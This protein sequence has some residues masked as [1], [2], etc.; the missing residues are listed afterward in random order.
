LAENSLAVGFLSDTLIYQFSRSGLRVYSINKFNNGSGSA[1]PINN[2]QLSSAE[3][4]SCDLSLDSLPEA[5]RFTSGLL[6]NAQPPLAELRR[7]GYCIST[8]L[9]NRLLSRPNPS[10]HNSLLYI[11]KNQLESIQ[12]VPYTEY[13]NKVDSE[14]H[15]K[16]CLNILK[17]IYEGTV[18]EL[19]CIRLQA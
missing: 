9:R 16:L 19:D 13:L 7:L 5:S 17:G 18:F 11:Y 2:N 4:Y 12:F 10:N 8:T 3:I 15:W 14:G 1:A 6:A